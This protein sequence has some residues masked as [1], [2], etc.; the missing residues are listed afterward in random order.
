MVTVMQITVNWSGLVAGTSVFH[1]LGGSGTTG[2]NRS[3]VGLFLTA[4]EP[5]LTP[6]V[7]WSVANDGSSYDSITGALVANWATGDSISGVGTSAD[8]H[9]V[10]Q[11]TQGLVQWTTNVIRG[12]RA[13]RG[14]TFIP[15]LGQSAVDV[16]GELL[17]SVRDTL[18][19]AAGD[20]R[21]SA[22]ADPVIWGRPRVVE[23]V[24]QEDGVFGVISGFAA[25]SELATQRPRR[26]A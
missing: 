7:N 19:D 14:R 20:Y 25:W 15:G 1:L 24:N 13:L 11:A 18:A 16:N 4:I 5:V 3:A 10:A 26:R 12:R 22:N 23:G 6:G 17:P 9:P 8:T 21:D 2:N